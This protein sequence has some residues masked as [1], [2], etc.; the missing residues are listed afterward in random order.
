MSEDLKVRCWTFFF[1]LGRPSCHFQCLSYETF[2][3]VSKLPLLRA[4]EAHTLYNNA[5]ILRNSTLWLTVS[6]ALR[7]SIRTKLLV[8]SKRLTWWSKYIRAQV[9]LPVGRKANWSSMVLDRM[10][11]YNHLLTMTFSAIREIIGVTE[12]GRKS[13]KEAGLVTLGTG[14]SSNWCIHAYLQRAGWGAWLPHQPAQ[15]IS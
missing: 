4:C 13:P 1:F 3:Y 8:S 11:G 6:K 7:K 2:K 9:V 15:C 5:D 12:M 10:A 14:V